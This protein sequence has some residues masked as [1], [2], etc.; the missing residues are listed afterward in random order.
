MQLR[1][2]HVQDLRRGPC[3]RLLYHILEKMQALIR[4]GEGVPS[5]MMTG[6]E[7]FFVTIGIGWLVSQMFRVIDWIER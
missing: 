7:M 2:G 3:S 4:T 5:P 1:D 6:W